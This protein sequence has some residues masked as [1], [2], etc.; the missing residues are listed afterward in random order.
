[1]P[2]K[3]TNDLLRTVSLEKQVEFLIEQ[4]NRLAELL[5]ASNHCMHILMEAIGEQ[6]DPKTRERIFEWA[7]NRTNIK[8]INELIDRLS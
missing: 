2:E 3:Q 5:D 6:A 1:L 8:Q 4:C 7:H